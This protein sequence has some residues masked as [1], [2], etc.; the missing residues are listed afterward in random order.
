MADC[1]LLASLSRTSGDH[2]LRK[3]APSRHLS[4]SHAR[5]EIL[6]SAWW[7]MQSLSN[8]SQRPNSLLTGKLT[9]ICAKSG[10]SGRFSRQIDVWIQRVADEFPKQK[11]REL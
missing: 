8:L 10:V 2:P 9:G 7:R 11:N 3:S 5:L 4:R 1:A 6:E